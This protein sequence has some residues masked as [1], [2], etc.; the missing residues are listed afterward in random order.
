M[1]N[2]RTLFS[3]ILLLQVVVAPDVYSDD[4]SSAK[5]K[6]IEGTEHFK[7]E[8]YSAALDSFEE[9][10]RIRPKP[11]VLYNIGM[12]RKALLRNVDALD[13]FEKY[14]QAGG[15]A[16]TERRRQKV[17]AEMAELRKKVGT[18]QITDIIDG[19]ELILD[20]RPIT[21][22]ERTITITLNPGQHTLSV[23]KAGCEPM[24]ST[25]KIEPEGAISIRAA[26]QPAKGILSVSCEGSSDAR[27]KIDGLDMGECPFEGPIPPGKHQLIVVAPGMSGEHCEV[28]IPP[29]G[30]IA[31]SVSLTPEKISVPKTKQPKQELNPPPPTP[32]QATQ[33]ST[34]ST[35]KKSRRRTVLK[36]TGIASAILGAGFGV[37]GGYFTYRASQDEQDGTEAA[38]DMLTEHDWERYLSLEQRRSGAVDD[39]NRHSA[40]MGVGYALGGVLVVSGIVMIAIGS[41]QN[42]TSEQPAVA[43]TGNGIS[44]R[45]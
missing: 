23:R 2:R 17:Q 45:F 38:T 6:F 14:L 22:T 11:S 8:E 26:L 28:E 13:A 10:Y 9:S 12:C 37:M 16:L 40:L 21:A 1:K 18:L 30:K 32:A 25:V 3:L 41:N 34:P 7:N 43:V 4:K 27:V 24:R 44:V 5:T 19:A 39:L 36:A 15:D 33:P 29:G 20:D 42:S 35:S 31:L